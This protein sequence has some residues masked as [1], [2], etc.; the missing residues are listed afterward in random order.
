[1]KRWPALDIGGPDPDLLLALLDDFQP[2]AVEERAD[3]LRAFFADPRQRD[4]A[5]DAL[6]PRFMVRAVDVPDED[7][8]R[9]SQEDLKPITVGRITVTPPW[10]ATTAHQ[11]PITTIS[12]PISIVIEPSMG[13][14]TG[15]HAT[16]RL[17]L[18]ALQTIDLD[19]RTMIDVGTGSGVLAIAARKLGAKAALGIDYDADAIQCARDNLALNPDVDGVSFELTDLRSAALPRADVITANLTGALL[20]RAARDLWNLLE[21]GGTLIVSGLQ[22]HERDE[23]F[24]AFGLVGSA[25]EQEEDGWIGASFNRRRSDEV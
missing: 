2:T 18:A 5:C 24:G 10:R 3:E 7:W 19:G 13:F 4:A 20:V 23:V 11:L 1:M 8:A 22:A 16:T 9:R 12:D 17:C 15:H 14:G 6:S 25:W 21:P